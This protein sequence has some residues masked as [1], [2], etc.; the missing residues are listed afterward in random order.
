MVTHVTP[1]IAVGSQAFVSSSGATVSNTAALVFNAL[2]AN[3]LPLSSTA[4]YVV[5]S[6]PDIIVSGY[7]TSF[8]ANHGP[9]TYNGTNVLVAYAG[10]LNSCALVGA[11]PHGC[12]AY[13]TQSTAPNGNLAADAMCSGVL[14][15]L[16]ETVTDPQLNA[17]HNT[18]NGAETGDICYITF[19]PNTV[20]PNGRKYTVNLTTGIFW[21]QSLYQP[22]RGVCAYVP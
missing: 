4:I 17:W 1:S 9:T 10:N 11:N 15:E 5:L 8:C 3:L 22:F 7:C 13:L 19:S 21:V 20:M 16:A 18:T 14:H 6:G 2:G 12:D